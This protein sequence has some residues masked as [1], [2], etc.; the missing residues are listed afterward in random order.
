MFKISIKNLQV[1]I[2]S[3][4]YKNIK[5]FDI[6]C[7]QSKYYSKTPMDSIR[8]SIGA[9]FLYVKFGYSLKGTKGA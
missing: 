3:E 5:Y 7:I 2:F 1:Y 9:F 6:Y 8:V 4:S